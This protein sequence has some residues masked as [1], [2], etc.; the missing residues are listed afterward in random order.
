MVTHSSELK[1]NTFQPDIYEKLLPLLPADKSASILDVGAGS[2][3]FCAKMREYGCQNLT[4]CD[5]PQFDFQ[6]EDVP[7]HGC[8]LNESIPLPDQSIDCTISI[9]VAEHIEHHQNYFSEIF[10]V[11]KPGGRAIFSTPNIQGLGSRM[12]YLLHGTTDGARR[13]FDPKKV[14][15]LQHV[16]CLG[17]QHFQ[18]YIHHNGGQIRS[19]ATNHFRASSLIFAPLVPLLAGT[20][21]MR[22]LGKKARSQRDRYQEHCRWHLSTPALFG[23]ILFVIAEKNPA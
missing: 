10:R 4:A 23:R 15:G 6:V 17:V 1:G 22:G 9:E 8:N 2:G 12:H 3:F 14:S 11:L 7:Y 5:L 19:L 18:Y 13:P 16:N 20:M 21:W